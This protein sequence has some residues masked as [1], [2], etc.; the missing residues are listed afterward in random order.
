LTAAS[1]LALRALNGA[2]ALGVPQHYGTMD[3][4]LAQV[5]TLTDRNDLAAAARVLADV[6]ELAA[7][8]G[9]KVYLVLVRVDAVRL[10]LA[11][12]DLDAARDLIDELR[13]LASTRVHPRLQR[14][15]DG[16]EA[17]WFIDAGDTA[18]AA[19]VIARLPPS[20]AV[21]ALLEAR[22]HLVDGRPELATKGLDG[23]FVTLRDELGAELIRV[24]AAHR[25]GSP[26]LPGHLDRVVSLASAERHVLPIL[27]AGPTVS[28]LVRAAAES[29][30]TGDGQRLAVD[31]G[32]APPA[33][34]V[35]SPRVPLTDRELA[36]LRY[37]PTRLTN[38]EIAAELFMSVNTVKTHLKSIYTKVG[39]TSRSDAVRKARALDLPSV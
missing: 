4:S 29:S 17:R 25:S 26:E 20:G 30:G 19:E 27:E 15:V 5:G 38:Q 6:H 2:A 10:L 7:H 24:A 35:A 8:Y 3:A 1:E 9:H 37:L 14:I 22:L 32:A 28:R 13:A 12:D 18:R 36:V 34:R 23:P 21:T 31:L 11:R 16:V 39:A 33:R